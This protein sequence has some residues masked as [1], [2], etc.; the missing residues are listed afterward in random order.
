LALS[1]AVAIA[2][3]PYFLTLAHAAPP[4][5]PSS[6]EIAVGYGDTERG[7]GAYHVDFPS[8]WCG[9]PGVQFIGSSTNYNG[10]STSE[11]N[12]IAGDWDG[13]AV[14]VTHAG[15]APITLTNLT[16]VLPLPSSGSVGKPSCSQPQR[17]ITFHLWFGQQYYNGNASDPAYYG[18]PV[19]LNPGGQA[20]FAG[21]SSDGAY[22]CPSGNY[23]EGPVNGTYDFDT[24]DSNFLT[25]CT[26]TNDTASDPRITFTA[27][28]YAPTTYVD[29][30]H[31]I[32]TG[33]FDSGMCNSTAANPEWPNESLGWRLVNS[34]CGEGCAEN[35]FALLE[36][37]S[38][39]KEATSVV[40]PSTTTSPGAGATTF[41]AV[42]G[43]AVIVIAAA[44][45]Y[46]LRRRRPTA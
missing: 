16:V 31:V 2:L 29:Q 19:T 12:C 45:L 36:Q 5:I 44:G 33:G 37:S 27:T 43:A 11:S 20:I 4:S 1:I 34:T 21:T 46:A 25:G 17:P 26:P 7:V 24:S 14:L 9:S 42:A 28:G 32:D 35:Q 23:P 40:T 8:P 15:S 3:A 30:G 22:V 6:L 13:G 10:N 38:S 18:A 39:S 41:Y